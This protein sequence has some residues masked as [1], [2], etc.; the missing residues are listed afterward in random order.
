MIGTTSVTTTPSQ[1]S[2][3][4]DSA[5]AVLA[6]A[7]SENFPVA[8]RVLSGEDR[9]RLEAV[10]GFARLVDDIGDL[11]PGD[12]LALLDWVEA[13]LDRAFDGRAEHPLLR[14][15]TPL[16]RECQVPRDPFLRLIEA[17]RR[18]QRQTRYQTFEDLCDYCTLSATPVGELVLYVFG[19]LTPERL[20]LSDSVCTALQLAEHWQ[21]VGEDYAMGRIYLPLEDLQRFGVDEAELGG[22]RPSDGF[23][24]LLSFEVERAR[25]LL[26]AGVPLVSSL[27][28]RARL[29]VAGY[30]AGGRA[31][32][33]EV[34]RSGYDVLRRSPKAGTMR[35]LA[36]VAGVLR[37]ARGSWR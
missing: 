3:S 26:A 24:R 20:R 31:A 30:V 6:K 34:E 23:R 33:D 8:L 2:L 13:D 18:D 25:P 9:E 5:D 36:A 16:A 4:G 14:R 28:G 32:L 29:A 19:A 1:P 15:L 11:A 27:N 37:E 35:R 22:V 21:D 7:S 10:Y 17:N 12:R